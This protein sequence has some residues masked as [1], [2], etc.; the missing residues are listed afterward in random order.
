MNNLNTFKI[1]P[2]IPYNI[3]KSVCVPPVTYLTF[4]SVYTVQRHMKH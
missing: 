2:R 3:S 4:Y 1:T